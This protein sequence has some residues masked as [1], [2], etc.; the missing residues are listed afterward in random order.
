MREADSACA[1]DEK[2]V[3]FPAAF[4]EALGEAGSVSEILDTTATWLPSVVD[5]ERASV[6]LIDEARK[7]LEV[8]AMGGNQAIAVGAVLPV[9]GSMV[10]QVYQEHRV[11]DF[12]DLS[13]HQNTPDAKMLVAS[14]LNSCMNGP[15]LSAGECFGTVNLAHPDKG[16][17]GPETASVLGAL[18]WLLGSSIR[19]HRQVEAMRLLAVTDALTG[20]LNRRAF[21]DAGNEVW[22]RFTA[23]GSA[24]AV[25][26]LDLDS[27]KAI[28][29]LYGHGAGDAVLSAVAGQLRSAVRGDDVAAR[30]GGEEFAIVMPGA[31]SARAD[32]L[33]ESLRARISDSDVVTEEGT[34]RYTVSIGVAAS[35]PG[36]QS[37]ESVYAR[38]DRA[39]YDAKRGGRNQV[40]VAA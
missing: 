33:A 21:I 5:A 13:K 34:I 35:L 38:A 6:T 12:A 28:N 30:V 26:L 8:F 25:A 7:S 14:G 9:E 37:F 20:L 17:F 16:F 11:I 2:Y 18:G 22:D 10:G 4:I 36:D 3:R 29:D 32:A 23:E 19:V 40:V 1:N 39:L 24:F 27:F 31:S 15:L